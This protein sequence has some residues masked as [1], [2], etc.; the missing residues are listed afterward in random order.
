MI[1]YSVHNPIFKKNLLS[2]I[3]GHK[4]IC[5]KFYFLSETMIENKSFFNL[6]NRNLI[7]ELIFSNGMKLDI[8]FYS[9]RH[10]EVRESLISGAKCYL[11]PNKNKKMRMIRNIKENVIDDINNLGGTEALK[12]IINCK[13]QIQDFQLIKQSSE[14]KRIPKHANL[15]L[16]N[17]ICLKF[18][19][20]LFYIYHYNFKGLMFESR[21][22]EIDNGSLILSS[23]FIVEGSLDK[24]FFSRGIMIPK[25]D[26]KNDWIFCRSESSM[27][28]IIDV[29]DI[30]KMQPDEELIH[31]I[32]QG[33]NMEK[34]EDHLNFLYLLKDDLISKKYGIAELKF[35]LNSDNNLRLVAPVDVVEPLAENIEF[36]ENIIQIIDD[37]KSTIFR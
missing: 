19:S 32:V 14:G 3:I 4:L 33:S 7:V 2:S 6:P 9:P 30:E 5:S 13:E 35:G 21:C 20:E 12:K 36:I 29:H 34:L 23:E 11:Y 31:K 22:Q 8:S 1:Y 37:I 27:P 15:F 28:S 16:I 17:G 25:I 24:R 26:F 18:K 10:L